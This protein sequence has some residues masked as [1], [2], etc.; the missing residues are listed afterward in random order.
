[1]SLRTLS[2][3]TAQQALDRHPPA[4]PAVLPVDLR[5]AFRPAAAS[6]W[7]VTAAG[8]LG[9]VGFT[10]ISVV[11]V[12]LDP[13]LVSFNISR[14]SS[15]LPAIESDRQ[16][17]I[18]LLGR[19]QGHLATRFAGDRTR[20]FVED[21]TWSTDSDGL[22]E[23]CDVAVRV[24]ASVTHLHDAG[25]SVLALARVRHTLSRPHEPLVHHQGRF[26]PL[27]PHPAAPGRH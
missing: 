5:E 2:L 15:S 17:A 25:D 23:L 3:P 6:T 12:S 10:A 21:G 1:M 7:V 11:S 18:H 14:G 8:P 26:A 19:H 20:R 4:P 22:P 27:A 24:V 16:V 9:P 13:P